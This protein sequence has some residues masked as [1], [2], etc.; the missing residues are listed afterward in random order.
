MKLAESIQTIFTSGAPLKNILMP[1]TPQYVA[2]PFNTKSKEP[3]YKYQRLYNYTVD[4]PFQLWSKRPWQVD[5]MGYNCHNDFTWMLRDAIGIETENLDEYEEIVLTDG[6]FVAV[7]KNKS[8]Q[9]GKGITLAI[10]KY[11]KEMR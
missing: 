1:L 5:T 9:K 6:A 11:A 3:V 4:N 8:G 7:V 10:T 2:I